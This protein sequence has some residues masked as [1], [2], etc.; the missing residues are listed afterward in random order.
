MRKKILYP[1][2][3]FVSVLSLHA[4][5]SIWKGIRVSRKWVQIEDI[6]WLKVYL[7]RHDYLLGLSYALAGAF[8]VY[9]FIRFRE[10]RNAGV[11]GVVGGLTLTGA[12]Y[13]GGCF[14]LGCC[15]SPML[16]VYLGLFG[17]S[18][19]GF[20]KPLVLILT[21][22]S[23]AIGFFWLEKKSRAC[24]VEGE[25]EDGCCDEHGYACED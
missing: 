2:A 3:A 20:A 5:Y 6:N 1:L 25:Q 19:M 17:S 9:A 7:G 14:L 4:S 18:F 23:I 8:T 10:R 13:V 24:C 11:A 21:A 16:A 15:G 12:L 22:T